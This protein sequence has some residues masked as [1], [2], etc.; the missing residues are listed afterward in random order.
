VAAI[1]VLLPANGAIG[2]GASVDVQLDAKA[3]RSYWTPARMRAALP[4]SVLAPGGPGVARAKGSPLHEAVAHPQRAPMRTHGK[5]FFTIPPYDLQ[6]SATSVKA[7]TGSLVITAGHCSY[8]HSTLNPVG[9]AIRNWEFVPAYRD[10]HAPFG[11]W[12]GTSTATA[13]WR[14]SGPLLSPTGEILGGDLRFD[15][16]A[17]IVERRNGS[18]LSSVVGARKIAFNRSRKQRYLAVGYPAE[19]QFN[20]R[21]EFSCDSGQIGRDGSLGAP[22]T[23]AIACDMTGGSSGGGWVNSHGTLLSVTSYSRGNDRDT[24]YGPYFGDAIRAFYDSVKNG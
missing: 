4:G 14:S 6:C 8:D 2:A 1:A 22:A 20:G 10:G 16:G 7:P 24:L 5:V 15:V 3:I 18:T 17:G 21:R 19:G 11:E 9:N 12:P 13:E 23:I